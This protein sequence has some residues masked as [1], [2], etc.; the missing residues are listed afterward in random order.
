MTDVYAGVRL[1][2]LAPRLDKRTVRFADYLPRKAGRLALP[3]LKP[4]VVHSTAMGGTPWGMLGNAQY[5]CCTD[6]AAGHAI[7]VTSAVVS[8][9][10]A[11]VQPTDADILAAY[12]AQGNPPTPG[13][14]DNGR[15]E[16]D[17]LNYWRQQGIAGEKAVAYASIDLRHL[18][19][20]VRYAIDLFG[21][22]YLGVA[23]PLTAQSQ[24][25]WKVVKGTPDAAAG[26]WGGHALCAV[27]FDKAGPTFVTWGRLVKASWAWFS[28]YTDEAY[29][30]IL[31]TW[32]NAQGATVE[33]LNVAALMTDLAAIGAVGA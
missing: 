18:H 16:L 7:Q 14:D 21:F 22:A 15:V 1:G 6:S 19:G 33:G 17:V 28:A 9:G 25:Y 12:W 32:L 31:P 20:Q 5:G 10:A 4:K 2:K 23:L 27:D 11:I 3:P 8:N 26:S 13:A 30:V 24:T 29:A